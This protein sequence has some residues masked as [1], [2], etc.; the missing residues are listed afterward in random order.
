MI[1]HAHGTQYRIFSLRLWQR[2]VGQCIFMKKQFCVLPYLCGGAQ[3]IVLNFK[4]KHTTKIMTR[5]WSWKSISI[6][7][8]IE[9]SNNYIISHTTKKYTAKFSFTVKTSAVKIC[10]IGHAITTFQS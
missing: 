8:D 5:Q 1:K 2:V 3:T 4:S 6:S 7:P 10:F 9:N